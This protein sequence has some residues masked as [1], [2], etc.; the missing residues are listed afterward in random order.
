V[1]ADYE[2]QLQRAGLRVSA[3]GSGGEPRAVEL[4]RHRFFIAT[5]FQPQLTSRPEAPHPIWLGFVR[6]AVRFRNERQG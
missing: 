3:R 2:E 1:N 5:L 4:P 6:A